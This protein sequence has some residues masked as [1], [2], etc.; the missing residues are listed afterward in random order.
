MNEGNGAELGGVVA[1]AKVVGQVT[2]ARLSV[3]TPAAVDLFDADVGWF[4]VEFPPQP[5]TRTAK[6]NAHDREGQLFVTTVLTTALSNG[7]TPNPGMGNQGL[8]L[9]RSTGGN[10]GGHVRKMRREKVGPPDAITRG[11]G[12]WPQLPTDPRLAP[13]SV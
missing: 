12:L 7:R 4:T 6:N 5:A 11:L 2:T 10:S 8:Q 9:S 3:R 1:T 13:M